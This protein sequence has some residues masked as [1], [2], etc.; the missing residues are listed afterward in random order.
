MNVYQKRKRKEIHSQIPNFQ[1]SKN[2]CDDYNRIQ[3]SM[4]ER[5]NE[6]CVLNRLF[7]VNSHIL[8]SKLKIEFFFCT[9]KW[10]IMN[11]RFY[12][13]F[14][15]KKKN[16]LSLALFENLQKKSMGVNQKRFFFCFFFKKKKFNFIIRPFYQINVWIDWF[17][18]GKNTAAATAAESWVEFS[19]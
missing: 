12:F 4:N 9:S 7:V 19:I 3:L 1:K 13:F 16:S 17:K 10:S 8:Y 11:D 15:L 6:W 2:K 18:N 14:N 5:M